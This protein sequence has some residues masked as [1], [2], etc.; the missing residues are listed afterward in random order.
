[1]DPSGDRGG[2]GDYKGDRSKVSVPLDLVLTMDGRSHSVSLE[3]NA[4]VVT[5]STCGEIS[6]FWAGLDQPFDSADGEWDRSR[7]AEVANQLL[8]NAL[9]YGAGSPVR[10]SVARRG[11]TAT[12]IVRDHGIGIAAE[13]RA[14]IFGP[15]QRAVSDHHYGGFGVGL[16]VAQQIVEAHRGSI[17]VDSSLGEG[18]TFTVRLPCGSPEPG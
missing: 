10:V 15:F 4:G 12:L 16:W 14:R 2:D 5:S 18:A 11:R 7:I 1:M 6:F 13:D 17:D 8:A 3:A 9:K